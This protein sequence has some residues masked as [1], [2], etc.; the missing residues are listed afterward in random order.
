MD[1]K[2]SQKKDSSGVHHIFYLNNKSNKSLCGKVT[3]KNFIIKHPGD[4]LLCLDCYGKTIELEDQQD[5]KIDDMFMNAKLD[6]NV[7]KILITERDDNIYLSDEALLDMQHEQEAELKEQERIRLEKN[8]ALKI[9]QERLKAKAAEKPK[10]S[11][12]MA[13][14][15]A[16]LA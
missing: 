12:R 11:P 4:D 2:Y 9:N 13:T 15:C 10:F 5:N 3:A 6:N 14:P 7:E 8:A 1:Y 16:A